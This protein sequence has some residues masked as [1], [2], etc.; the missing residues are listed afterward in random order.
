MNSRIFLK[1]LF[2]LCL[3]LPAHAKRFVGQYTEFELPPG[4][5]CR[6][7]GAE[8]VCQ[9]LNKDRQKEAIIIFTAKIRS[10][11]DGYEPY[12][13][14]LKKAKTFTLPGSGGTQISEAKYA[15]FVTINNHRWVDALHLASEVPGFYTRYLATVKADLAVVITFSVSKE[16][17][18]NYQQI[19]DNIIKTLRVFRKNQAPSSQLKLKKREEDLFKRRDQNWIDGSGEP[20]DISLQQTV[21]QRTADKPGFN[22]LLWL[23][24]AGVIAFAIIKLRKK[25]K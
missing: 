13:S 15:K 8:W 3:I 1:I 24:V 16:H 18:S 11:E 23:I 12:L 9:S 7:E 22:F 19:F 20:P 21:P 17:Y 4:W 25:K 14:Y 2:A 10:K 5:Q 6:L